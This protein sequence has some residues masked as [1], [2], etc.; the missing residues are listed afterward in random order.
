[1]RAT[2]LEIS[3]KTPNKIVLKSV[4]TTAKQMRKT[5]GYG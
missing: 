5:E 1:M 3:A 4:A 2:A